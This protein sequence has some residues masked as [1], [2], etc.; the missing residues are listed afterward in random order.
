MFVTINDSVFKVKVCNS[1]SEKAEGMMRKKFTDFDGML[2][3]MGGEFQCFHMKNCIIPLDIILID[4]NL[5]IGGI[6]E[7]CPPCKSEEN[8]LQYCGDASYVLEIDG[9]LCKTLNINEGD[10]CIFTF[11]ISE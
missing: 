1:P 6:F 5:K 9:G 2:F 8:C 3:L 10:R 7:D 4:G 11:D